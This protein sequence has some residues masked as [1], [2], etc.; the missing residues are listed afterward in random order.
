MIAIFV[1]G[2]HAGADRPGSE[3]IE[4]IFEYDSLTPR[5]SSF[6][7]EGA[8]TCGRRRLQLSKDRTITDCRN[9]HRRRR[10]SSRVEPS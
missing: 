6:L 4:R 8:R 5:F 9:Q 2:H 7:I 1:D 10:R 3:S